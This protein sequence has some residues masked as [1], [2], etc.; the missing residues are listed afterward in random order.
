[1][2][3]NKYLNTPSYSFYS[4]LTG[5]TYGNRQY[6]ISSLVSGQILEIRRDRA[7]QFDS[8]AIAVF[9][10]NHQIGFLSKE[11]AAKLSPKLDSGDKITVKVSQITGGNN[12]YKGVNILIDVYIKQKE[13]SPKNE[14]N[15]TTDYSEPFI[16]TPNYKYI[17]CEEDGEY[18][19]E[20]AFWED[21]GYEDYEEFESNFPDPK[22]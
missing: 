1:M 21:M 14:M 4:K 9:A 12:Q 15:D 6:Y 7:N 20:D 5:V 3:S 2:S 16:R 17:Y 8:N 19:L 18:Y 13:F 22:D 10:N 11:L